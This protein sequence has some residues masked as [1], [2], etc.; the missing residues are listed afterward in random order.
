MH[1]RD[2]NTLPDGEDEIVVSG[3][4]G[5]IDA[6]AVSDQPADA[7]PEKRRKALYNAFLERMLPIMKEEHPGLRKIYF[8]TSQ[9]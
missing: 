7:H 1:S 2:L 3:I 6:L 9:P 8:K 4:E 5:A